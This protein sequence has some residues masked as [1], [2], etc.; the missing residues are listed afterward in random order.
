[1]EKKFKIWEL[2]LMVGLLIGLLG[3]SADAAQPLSRWQEQE[4]QVR[5]QVSLFPFGIAEGAEN[6]M[7]EPI[8]EEIQEYE[9]K[10]KVL[11]W[12]EALFAPTAR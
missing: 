10:F 12:W 9:I 11:E 5:Y 8:Q 3:N 4:N 1:M 6:V 2:A 7:A